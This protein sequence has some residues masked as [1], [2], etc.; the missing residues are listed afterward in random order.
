M[1]QIIL[2]RCAITFCIIGEACFLVTPLLLATNS[3]V[4]GTVR[5]S[6]AALCLWYFFPWY[7]EEVNNEE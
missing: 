4:L 2:K 5:L 6:I 1:R 7:T 3:F